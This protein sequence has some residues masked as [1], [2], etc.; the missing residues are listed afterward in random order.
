MTI[1]ACEKKAR[2]DPKLK[3]W[4]TSPLYLLNFSQG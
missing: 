3:H 2:G 1:A 4:A